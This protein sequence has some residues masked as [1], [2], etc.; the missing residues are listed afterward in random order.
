MS[1]GSGRA[2]KTEGRHL[3]VLAHLKPSILCVNADII[4]LAHDLIIAIARLENDPNC[5]AYR[6]RRKIQPEVRRLLETTGL[7]LSNV[8]GLRER[9]RFQEYF[10]DRYKIV[11]Y[12]GLNCDSIF[13]E[14]RIDGPKSINLF[15]F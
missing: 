10:R 14:G 15:L 5:K 8:G 11:V 9:H 4:C 13:F 2:V 7:D 6:Q 1:L 12:G 3:D